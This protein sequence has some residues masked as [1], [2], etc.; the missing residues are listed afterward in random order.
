MSQQR[1]TERKEIRV[2]WWG[3]QREEGEEDGQGMQDE[4]GLT[5]TVFIKPT[6]DFNKRN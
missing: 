2:R 3:E 6:N 1:D 4:D 5:K